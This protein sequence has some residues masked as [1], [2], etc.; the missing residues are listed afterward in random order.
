M[1][2]LKKV[3]VLPRGFTNISGTSCIFVQYSFLG[4]THQGVG[5]AQNAQRGDC[6]ELSKYLSL[7]MGCLFFLV[8]VYGGC[9]F[10]KKKKRKK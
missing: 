10:T 4:W 7:K 6:R 5:L 1:F 2:G 3:K 8:T 9:D